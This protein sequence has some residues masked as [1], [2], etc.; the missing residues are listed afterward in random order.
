MDNLVLP[1]A[2][3]AGIVPGGCQAVNDD[4]GFVPYVVEIE[5][6][7]ISQR[8]ISTRGAAGRSW[9]MET[10]CM[11][12]HVCSVCNMFPAELHRNIKQLSGCDANLP[13]EFKYKN[14]LLRNPFEQSLGTETGNWTR[15]SNNRFLQPWFQHVTHTIVDNFEWSKK[16][17]TKIGQTTAAGW[18]GRTNLT[19]M[20]FWP[21]ATVSK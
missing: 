21:K 15:C 10:V 12:G 3:E 2:S 9:W 1:V 11:F 7:W 14:W 8:W 20:F 17:L 4:P 18:L 13:E 6:V 19:T 5:N 16:R